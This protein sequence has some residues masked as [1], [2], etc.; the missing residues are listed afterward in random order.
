MRMELRTR[1]QQAKATWK[2]YAAAPDG[3]QLCEDLVSDMMRRVGL[4]T[5]YTKRTEGETLPTSY[6]PSSTERRQ[7]WLI[8]QVAPVVKKC[9]CPY[10]KRDFLRACGF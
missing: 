6:D 10:F 1:G 9:E 2:Q 5:P 7:R 8:E 3:S 4:P